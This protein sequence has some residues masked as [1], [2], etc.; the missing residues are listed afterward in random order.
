MS[1]NEPVCSCGK[2]GRTIKV[3][4]ITSP[5]DGVDYFSEFFYCADRDAC[6]KAEAEAL[7]VTSGI[8]TPPTPLTRKYDMRFHSDS[9]R[10]EVK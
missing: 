8:P 10:F 6:A 3:S 7:T 4:E 5:K 1:V 9:F 2:C